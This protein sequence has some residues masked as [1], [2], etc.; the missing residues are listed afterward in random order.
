MVKSSLAELDKSTAKIVIFLASSEMTRSKVSLG[1]AQG[2]GGGMYLKGCLTLWLLWPPH[3]EALRKPRPE[4]GLGGAGPLLGIL[5]W[6]AAPI[7][8][9]HLAAPLCCHAHFPGRGNVGMER[10]VQLS[11]LRSPR[12]LFQSGSRLPATSWLRWAGDSST[13]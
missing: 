10:G 2:T 4:E 1:A 7:S 5:A 3:P 12:R 8:A 13:R 9:A 6:V 11:V